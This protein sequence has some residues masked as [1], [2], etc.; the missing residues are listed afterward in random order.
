MPIL[1]KQIGIK[2]KIMDLKHILDLDSLSLQLMGRCMGSPWGKY[3]R[4]QY[5]WWS[6]LFLSKFHSLEQCSDHKDSVRK[7]IKGN[8]DKAFYTSSLRF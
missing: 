2:I 3:F 7:K 8:I 1:N 5:A 4:M 6:H